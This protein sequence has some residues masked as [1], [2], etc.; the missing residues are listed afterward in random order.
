MD[1]N[2]AVGM[3]VG[4]Q[5]T[6]RSKSHQPLRYRYPSMTIP[7]SSSP[8]DALLSGECCERSNSKIFGQTRSVTEEETKRKRRK[9]RKTVE[10]HFTQV[11]TRQV[12][13]LRRSGRFK[14]TDDHREALRKRG[15]AL[16]EPCKEYRMWALKTV[17]TDGPHI[18]AIESLLIAAI[19]E[20]SQLQESDP[21]VISKLGST[22]QKT[23]TEWKAV[24]SP[25]H[26]LERTELGDGMAITVHGEAD[27]AVTLIDE[28]EHAVLMNRLCLL[29]PSNENNL[30]LVGVATSESWEPFKTR[31]EAQLLA[32]LKTSGRRFFPG[33]LTTG[34]NWIFYV[35][36]V[37]DNG[38]F[39]I[40]RSQAFGKWREGD[41]GIV[42]ALM[43]DL[44]RNPGRLPDGLELCE[45]HETYRFME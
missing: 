18:P 15:A 16:L 5:S 20:A 41:D 9:Y 28:S 19:R 37:A 40:H 12:D 17:Y 39:S 29:P 44:M 30:L 26:E 34:I 32:V 10:T 4:V 11:S 21:I 33:V 25:K 13:R 43:V 7:S 2:S 14:L 42:V 6:S 1:P 38:T 24:L 31:L 27:Y 3:R 23:S 36:S 22:T 8:F 45:P 35:A